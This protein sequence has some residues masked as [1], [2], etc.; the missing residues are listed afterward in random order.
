MK[1]YFSV[2]IKI[3][4][5]AIFWI[6]SKLFDFFTF[7]RL[8][9]I[10]VCSFHSFWLIF[11]TFI[12]I[13]TTFMYEDEYMLIRISSFVKRMVLHIEEKPSR[14][15]FL[16]IGVS[17]DKELIDKLDED[18]LPIG[19]QAITDRNKIAKFLHVLNKNPYNHKFLVMDVFFRDPSPYDS[20]LQVE[21]DSLKNYLV[22]YH[23]S[24]DGVPIN[25]VIKVNKGLSD[26]E[27]SEEGLLGVSAGGFAKYKLIQEDTFKTLPLL[28][29]EKIYNKNVI[30]G[31]LFDHMDDKA[32]F[33]TFVV[34]HRIRPYD[35]FEAPDSIR[36]DRIYLNELIV[37]PDELIWELTKNRILVIGDYEDRDIHDTIYGSMPGPLILTNAFL[38]LE[39]F[40]NVIHWPFILLLFIG[41]YMVSYRC[42]FSRNFLSGIF[43][44][45]F[46]KTNKFL[47][48][49]LG[50]F[51]FFLIMSLLSFFLF[52]VHLSILLL[53]FYMEIVD[54]LLQKF[55]F[56]K[57]NKHKLT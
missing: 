46:F 3:I 1:R 13:N 6:G 19:N 10:F 42:F 34:D 2:L 33:P 39:A 48:N 15:K 44:I 11:I 4:I 54:F 49:F 7:K 18:G 35:L 28:M 24:K 14:D 9:T 21:F 16:F 45:K 43:K 47:V 38:A 5:S 36:Y 55:V 52:D 53:A 41:F 23:K 56:K 57:E 32:L 26:Y 31:W 12:W 8:R 37:L 29:Y 20:L 50:Y 25:P 51:I 17:W 27:N 30:N 22:S 40:D